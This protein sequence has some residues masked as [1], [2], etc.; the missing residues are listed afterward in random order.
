M[1]RHL[2]FVSPRAERSAT[3]VAATI[4]AAAIA[5]W[6]APALQAQESKT[7]DPER[8]V[9]S[10]R[11]APRIFSF[12]T[13]ASSKR[14]VLG[15]TLS[16][17]TRADTAGILIEEVDAKGPA[18]KAGVKAGDIITDINGVNLRLSA[19][20]AADPELSGVSQRRLQRAMADTKV[21][22][23]VDLRLRSGSAARTVKVKTVSAADLFGGSENNML[24]PA[25]SNDTRGAIGVTIGGSNSRRDTLGLFVSSVVTD[26]PA[27]KAGIYEGDRI[28]AVNGVDVRVPKEDAADMAVASSRVD[29]FV[30]A[31][32]AVAPGGSVKLRVFSGGKYREISVGTVKMSELPGGAAN[33]FLG[34]EGLHILRGNGPTGNRLQWI[35]PGNSSRRIVIP[36][37]SGDGQLRIRMNG[38]E[39][40]FNTDAFE[41]SMS[42][43][44]DQMKELG[45][46]MQ[47]EFRT[48]PMDSRQRAA[49]GVVHFRTLP[50]RTVTIL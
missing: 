11:T 19:A 16:A 29:R 25:R 40:E 49:D 24:F 14:A 42:R 8:R 5:M 44:K 7:Q 10:T 41:E 17:G 39:M 50:R 33:M 18:A 13:E 3:C 30:K 12:M 31:V 15:V 20:D 35:T 21:G 1:R 23:E 6:A 22:D 28:A 45:R 46:D 2:H 34:D 9:E 43:L 4:V 47:F 27:E 36:R 48:A 26:G 32:Q 38:K 37:G